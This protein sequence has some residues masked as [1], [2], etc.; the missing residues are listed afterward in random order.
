M[1]I[2]LFAHPS[3]LGQQSMPRFTNMLA[4]EMRKRGHEVDIYSPKALFFRVQSPAVL[5]KWLG[6]IDQFVVFP[7]MVKKLIKRHHHTLYVFTDHA[8]G[9]WV[10]VVKHLPH[11]VICHD[12]LAQRSAKGEIAQNPTGWSGRRYQQFIY[13]GYATAANFISVSKKTQLDLHR[14]L[15]RV[16]VLSK[17]V[18]NGLNKTFVPIALK[19]ARQIMSKKTGV[20]TSG[21]YI[22]HVGGNQWYKNRVGVLEIYNAWRASG[23]NNLPLLLIGVLPSAT[24][25]LEIE[26][27][28]YR[29]Q[30]HVLAQID[31]EY[32]NAAYSGA[33]VLL[34]PSLAEG[35]GWPIAEAMASGC[36]VVTTGEAPMTEV[37]DNAA[38]YIP[39]QP[40]RESEGVA[41]A[42]GAAKILNQVIDLPETDRVKMVQ[43]GLDNSQ[44]FNTEKA[45]DEFEKIFLEI[46]A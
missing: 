17:V 25:K 27:S 18:Y 29:E 34:F 12:F 3:F 20:D 22:L 8:L 13:E 30:I 36:V 7:A 5:K 37:G 15:G 16:P 10:P 28:A 43:K 23:N 6:Y 39:S 32:I 44:R 35:F 14:F 40:L 1:K 38:I 11:V 45:L 2:I 19:T 46:L 26:R 21:G 31:D 33:T 9:M 4:E 42:Q 41:W 24:L